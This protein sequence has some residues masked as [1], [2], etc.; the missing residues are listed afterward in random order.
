MIFSQAFL[1][2]K[3]DG[4]YVRN[5]HTKE[6]VAFLNQD[7]AERAAGSGNSVVPMR[8]GLEL[9]QVDAAVDI[10]DAVKSFLSG[11]DELTVRDV[12]V[13]AA[14]T[15]TTNGFTGQSVPEF[16]ALG[17]SEFSEALEE[18]RAGRD[19]AD[20]YFSKQGDSVSQK[21][22]GILAEIADVVIRCGDFIGQRNLTTQFVAVVRQKMAYN[23]TRSFRHGGKI[24]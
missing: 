13:K 18:H 12:C 8:V 6:L 16:I 22:E 3:A 14:E 4:S 19:P 7:D 17:H 20:V 10:R 2:E 9:G 11:S 21:P 5:A 23:Q 24:I 15:A 1:I